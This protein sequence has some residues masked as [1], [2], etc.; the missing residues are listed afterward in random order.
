MI[1]LAYSC[2]FESD[3]QSMFNGPTPAGKF[4]QRISN[5]ATSN[6]TEFAPQAVADI[7]KS[8]KGFLIGKNLISVSLKKTS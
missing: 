6:M 8:K 7:G 1:L 5:Y 4:S 2:G 3:Q